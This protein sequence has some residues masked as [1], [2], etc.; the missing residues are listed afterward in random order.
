M[1]KETNITKSILLVSASLKNDVPTFSGIPV[2]SECPFLEILFNPEQKALAIISKH[3]NET[4][5]FVPRLDDA[6]N[7]QMNTNRKTADALPIKQERKLVSM[8]HEYYITDKKEIESF[9]KA[10]VVNEDFDYGK[11]LK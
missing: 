7:V 10:F 4:F 2:T 3:K 8:Y 1:S 5:Q 9:L 6:G 11:F